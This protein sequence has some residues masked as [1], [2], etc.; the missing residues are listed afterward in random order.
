MMAM[1]AAAILVKNN[2]VEDVVIVFLV[3]RRTMP[4]DDKTCCH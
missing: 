3:I 2:A 4:I 1:F